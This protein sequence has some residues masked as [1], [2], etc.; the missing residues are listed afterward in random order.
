MSPFRKDATPPKPPQPRFSPL[1][2]LRVLTK[3]LGRALW[4]W[5]NLKSWD[6]TSEYLD[7]DGVTRTSD[8]PTPFGC[9]GA[10]LMVVCV[11]MT[12]AHILPVLFGGSGA[13]PWFVYIVGWMTLLRAWLPAAMHLD[14]P[15]S[16]EWWKERLK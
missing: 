9:V 4:W 7:S 13:S 3:R 5:M 1:R 6:S 8:S 16:F 11:V 10:V 14:E 15:E 2:P 12:T